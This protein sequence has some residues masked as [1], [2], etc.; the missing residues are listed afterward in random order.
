M[1]L[2]TNN[3]TSGEELYRLF[4]AGD[5]G[6]FEDFV[7]FYK[8]ELSHFI[9]G[10]VRDYNETEH[11]MIETFAQLVTNKKRFGGQSSIKTYLFAIGK[12]LSMRLLKKRGREQPFSFEEAAEIPA[13]EGKT[14]YSILE[15]E[16]NRQYVHEAMHGLK[17]EHRAVLQLLYF[18]DMS[19]EQAGRAMGKNVRQI[20]DLAYRAKIALKKRL[21]NSGYSYTDIQFHLD[22]RT[23]GRLTP[24]PPEFDTLTA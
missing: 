5:N 7:S 20:K 14:P 2:K 16:E 23:A 9:Y 15:K 12:N 8:D 19:Y 6:A 4:L 1:E 24:S 21:E 17:K 3:K 11:L 10:I 18:E 22:N 13:D